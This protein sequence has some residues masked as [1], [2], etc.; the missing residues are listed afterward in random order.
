[1]RAAI[2]ML[3]S[4][5]L[6]FSA[7]ATHKAAAKLAV[8][9]VACPQQA[10]KPAGVCSPYDRE[11]C[12][13]SDGTLLRDDPRDELAPYL[14]KQVSPAVYC[15]YDAELHAAG[16]VTVQTPEEQKRRWEAT[17]ARRRH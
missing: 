4:V 17:K 16:V 5:A 8:I 9:N 12:R 10:P 2:L 1:M 14:L 11:Y 7:S 6:S 13:F 3:G 15:R